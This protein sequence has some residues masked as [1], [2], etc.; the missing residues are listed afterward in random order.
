M[1]RIRVRIYREAAATAVVGGVAAIGI[2]A[3]TKENGRRTG[4][5]AINEESKEMQD[6][7]FETVERDATPSSQRNLI[8][9]KHAAIARGG[10]RTVDVKANDF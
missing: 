5:T 10:G 6:K 8:D 1:T 4:M 9:V 3:A 7:E 2:V